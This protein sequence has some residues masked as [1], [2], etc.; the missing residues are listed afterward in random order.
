M[1]QILVD[2]HEKILDGD[3]YRSNQI[4]L[5]H[6]FRKRLKAELKLFT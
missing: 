5:D 6:L 3:K 1:I 2:G 4:I